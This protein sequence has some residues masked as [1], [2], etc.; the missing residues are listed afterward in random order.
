M[1]TVKG[2]HPKLLF[3][4]DLPKDVS[5]TNRLDSVLLR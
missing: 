1:T 4:D 5:E 3:G 2:D